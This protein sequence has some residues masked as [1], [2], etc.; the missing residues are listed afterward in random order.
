MSITNVISLL[1]G[2]AFFLFGMFTM[3]AALKKVAGNQMQIILGRLTSTRFKGVLLGT[4]VTAIIQSSSATS[5]M[6]VSFVTS[7]IMGLSQAI[8]VIMGACIGTTATGWILTLAGL[9]SDSAIGTL[10]STEVVFAI[11]AVI[12]VVFYMAAKTSSRRNVGV[13]LVSL[14]I[15]MT[16]MR[17]MSGA[18]EP[19]EQS[20]AFL[21][22]MTVVSNPVLCIVL[23]IGITALL[24]SC[25]ATIGIL[26]ALSMT[27]VVTFET[28]IPMV[29]GMSIGACVPVLISSI[30]ANKD[31]K[32]A[33]FSYLYFNLFGGV[34]FM[35]V[36]L[37]AGATDWG[38]EFFSTTA[39]SVHIAIFNTAFKSIS[40]VLIYPFIP[41][42]EKL[43]CMSFR[44]APVPTDAIILDEMLL[45]YPAQ[46]IE[47]SA[48]VIARMAE[49]A[50]ENMNDA[51]A[52][53]TNFD[54]R[55]FEALLQRE[56]E[57]DEFEDKLSEFL[58]RLNAKKLSLYETRQ[59][60]KFLRG[61]TDLERISDHSVN[62]ARL[63]LEISA[64]G[65]GF[66]QQAAMEIGVCTRAINEIL[67]IT[68]EALTND[69]LDAA[70]HVEPLEEVIDALTEDL[71]QRHIDRLQRNVCSLDT[72]FIFNDCI[73]NFERTA[74]HCS[75]IA[76]SVIELYDETAVE[77]HEYL[78]T[79]KQGDSEFFREYL[80]EYEQKYARLLKD[81][82]DLPSIEQQQSLFA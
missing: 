35:A 11:V 41:L 9:G 59:T 61:M 55:R 54:R 14:A 75:N 17:A 42:L 38:R 1:G 78:R 71:K 22:A 67:A 64:S 44:D 30:G 57:E 69:N 20:E 2:L 60:A 39:N 15:L 21:H 12:G 10:L 5:I 72:G 50:V 32:R 45:N 53:L 29:I 73:N 31:G 74:D 82:E 34:I 37:I 33:A 28:A 6:V 68:F 66:S 27:G 63:A 49:I 56:N 58:V 25:S 47:Q 16:G 3:G 40:V 76:V 62:I 65:R 36:F 18:M 43:V 19:L 4:F 80:H 52:L 46:A 24:Q 13:V 48:R 23:G 8:S 70:Y 77:T 79:L 7:G 51:T 81:T 26:Q